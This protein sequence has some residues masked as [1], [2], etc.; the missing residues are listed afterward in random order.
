LFKLK[1]ELTFKV[2]GGKLFNLKPSFYLYVGSAF[3]SGGLKSRLLRH[4]KRNKKPH[5]HLDFITTSS[6]FCP[7]SAYLFAKKRIECNLAGEL[8]KEFNFVPSFG[9]SDCTCPSHLFSI[10]NLL[11]LDSICREFG[12]T[13]SQIE[14]TERGWTL[15]G[16]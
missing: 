7:I 13:I 10:D 9:S 2:R 15:K 11:K 1:E 3:G 8:L 16:Y 6:S 5:W 4:L 12:A 14:K